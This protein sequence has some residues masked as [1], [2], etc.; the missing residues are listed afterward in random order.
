MQ[1]LPFHRLLI[2][3]DL[4]SS[5][6]DLLNYID[7]VLPYIPVTSIHFVHVYSSL[8]TDDSKEELEDKMTKAM[9]G[10]V[11]QHLT[12]DGVEL[13]YSV[14]EGSPSEEILKTASSH[15]ADLI[16]LMNR[17]GL[18][19]S[20]LLQD[21]ANKSNASLWMIPEGYDHF[22]F[23]KFYI[24]LQFNEHNAHTLRLAYGLD[25]ADKGHN[26]FVCEHFYEVPS[27]YHYSGK[28]LEEYKS[29]LEEQRQQDFNRFVE[30]NDLGALGLA[31]N[32]LSV[33]GMS[34]AETIYAQSRKMGADL[35][36]ISAR[37]RSKVSSFLLGSVTNE[38]VLLDPVAPMILVKN[39]KGN[40]G[41]W[42]AIQEV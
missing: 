38:L 32:V 39:P 40:M 7:R 41:L 3:L 28:P 37:G 6:A 30:E 25:E 42:Q 13:H 33:D 1:E 21:L 9:H 10:L 24:P 35:I 2:G 36:L 8:L 20:A 12:I 26:L 27:G 5:D 34:T 16:F 15:K 19:G 18:K 17:V 22:Q 31:C 4:T 14:H 23:T 11:E 29:I